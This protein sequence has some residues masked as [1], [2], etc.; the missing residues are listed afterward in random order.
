MQQQLYACNV[1]YP[2]FHI[3]SQPAH[4]ISD[5]REVHCIYIVLLKPAAVLS[6]PTV[7]LNIKAF[8]FVSNYSREQTS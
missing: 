8:S 7:Q 6:L 1:P 2:Y 3:N 5:L 4:A